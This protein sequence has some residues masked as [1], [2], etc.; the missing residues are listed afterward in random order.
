M[1]LRR[2]SSDGQSM[3]IAIGK[4]QGTLFAWI[5]TAVTVTTDA[6]H[7][8]P[9]SLWSF[10]SGSADHQGYPLTPLINFMYGVTFVVDIVYILLLR[11]KLRQEGKPVWRRL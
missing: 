6:T 5:A 7:Q 1:L 10:W 11:N 3:W 4:W 2:D 9:R 8:W